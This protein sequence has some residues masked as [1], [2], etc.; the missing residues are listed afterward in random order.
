MAAGSG[1]DD[2]GLPLGA[3]EKVSGCLAMLGFGFWILDC[4][5]GRDEKVS[6]CLAA[7]GFGFWIAAWI[8]K[9]E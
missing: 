3:E 8:E 5:L 1:S 2:F 7:L 4:R 6:G 9:G